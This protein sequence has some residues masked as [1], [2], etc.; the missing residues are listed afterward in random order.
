[1]TQP[2]ETQADKAAAEKAAEKAAPEPRLGPGPARLLVLAGGG[3]ALVIYLLSFFD[4]AIVGSLISVLLLAG[5]LL[6]GAVLLP[7]AG[8]LLL[9]GAVA[10]LLGFLLLLQGIA[11]GA[12]TVSAV[13][14]VIL[15][16]GF[17]EAGAL[18]GA[19]LFD[20][21]VL[22]QPAPRPAGAPK[23]FGAQQPYG[24]GQQPGYGR[25]GGY[26]QQPGFGGQQPY[27]YGQQP[28]YGAQQPGY[29]QQQPGYGA[30]GGFGGYAP[31][32]GYGFSQPSGAGAPGQGAESGQPGAAKPPAAAEQADA[33]WYGNVASN[34]VPTQTLAAGGPPPA[35]GAPGGPG[36]PPAGQPNPYGVSQGDAG[37]EPG[38]PK[39]SEQTRIISQQ[40][41]D[42]RSA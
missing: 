10:G 27:G 6:G 29:G 11:A 37:A 4:P 3:L 32:G 15:V 35:D 40:R 20:A 41:G 34:A 2:A 17:L 14:V 36:T 7:K 1:M 28:G 21:G 12:G 8:R 39:E 42:D 22:K 25:Q 31:Q 9:P 16:L 38:R 19:L 23:G 26:G 24:Y 5:G 33:P 13:T 30:Q 18:V